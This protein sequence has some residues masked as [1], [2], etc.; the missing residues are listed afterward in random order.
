MPHV[1][2]PASLCSSVLAF[3]VLSLPLPTQADIVTTGLDA[4]QRLG[5]RGA[6]HAPKQ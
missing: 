5:E 6:G 1:S 2:R 3:I 4:A